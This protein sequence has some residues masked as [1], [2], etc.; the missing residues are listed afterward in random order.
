MKVVFS[1]TVYDDAGRERLH[2]FDRVIEPVRVYN[3][4]MMDEYEIRLR[5]ALARIDNIKHTWRNDDD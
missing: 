2:E 4:E 3:D 1:V 5:F